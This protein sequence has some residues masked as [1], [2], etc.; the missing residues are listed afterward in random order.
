MKYFPT[1]GTKIRVP[2]FASEV[3]VAKV[4]GSA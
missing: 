2:G 3:E 1:R 4:I